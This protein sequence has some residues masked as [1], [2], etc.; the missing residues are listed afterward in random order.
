MTTWVTPPI[1]IGTSL[2]QLLVSFLAEVCPSPAF[3]RRRRRPARR[4]PGAAP[5]ARRSEAVRFP[6]SRRFRPRATANPDLLRPDRGPGRACGQVCQPQSPYRFSVVGGTGTGAGTRGTAPNDRVAGGGDRGLAA[7][8]LAAR[9]VR[10]PPTA[11]NPLLGR[12]STITHGRANRASTVTRAIADAMPSGLHVM[13][14][15]VRS[16]TTS[17]RRVTARALASSTC[18]VNS[19]G[20]T[21]PAAS[22]VPRQARLDGPAGS[23]VTVTTTWG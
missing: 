7:A 16:T 23:A 13:A 17:A 10:V 8:A 6:W 4:P 5:A 18:A 12:R 11:S 3:P 2:C 22:R 9:R 20:L 14:N 21:W 1:M 19:I 15:S